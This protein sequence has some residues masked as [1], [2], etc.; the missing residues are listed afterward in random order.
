[1]PSYEVYTWEILDGSRYIELTG[2]RSE[3][4]TVYGTA[5][6]TAHIRV[7]YEYGVTEP[8]M[9]T[10]INQKVNKSLTTDYEIAVQ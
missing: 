8:D 10:G 2:T 1:M 6:G 4:C 5:P 9:L 7:T 3:T